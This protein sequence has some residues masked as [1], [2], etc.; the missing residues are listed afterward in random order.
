MVRI[1]DVVDT[2]SDGSA[3]WTL[4]VEGTLAD[5]ALP[6]LRRAWRRAREA[7][8]GGAIRVDLADIDFIDATG[9]VLLAEMYRAGVEIIA[10]GLAAATR[11]EVVRRA[12]ADRRA[13]GSARRR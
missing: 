12:A 2:G 5:E 8:V 13:Q 1:T 3:T 10:R 4:K 11:D 9:K 7:S 6:E